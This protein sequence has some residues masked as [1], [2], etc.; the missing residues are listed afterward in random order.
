MKKVS[1][2]ITG[3][4]S[5][6]KQAKRQGPATGVRLQMPATKPVSATYLDAPPPFKR[7]ENIHPRRIL[8]RVRE[9]REREFHSVTSQAMFLRPVTR[10]FAP[11][12][13]ADDLT[14]VI[15]TELLEPGLQQL[16]SNVGEP[17]V[18]V[19][20]DV[21]LYTGNWYAARS[22]DGGQTFQY[23]DPFTTFPDPPNLG[24]CCDQVANYIASIDT[25]VWLLQ[26]GP[27]SGPQADNIQRLAFATTQES[28][29][30][31]LASVRHNHESPWRCRPVPRL[32]GY[33][34]RREFSLCDDEH[35][36]S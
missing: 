16:A 26:Y 36:Y 21:V 7:R 20:S 10:A 27:K 2:K 29:D 15:N 17:S 14:L 34:G 32:P 33:C 9:G 3:R 35:I 5:S 18:A 31:P 24:F 13:A 12:A 30:G 4:K 8:P 19:N 11:Q 6:A 23:L 25:F 28:Q 1:S 22:I